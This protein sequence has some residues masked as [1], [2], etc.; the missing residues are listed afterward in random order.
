M[1]KFIIEE[2]EIIKR[3]DGEDEP[4]GWEL[5]INEKTV[6]GTYNPEPEDA[7]LSR[8]LSFVFNIVG[9][10]KQAYEAGK[11]GDKLVIL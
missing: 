1:R 11:R 4:V 8:D 6:L 9:L 3:V 2:R 10:L 5:N 7:T